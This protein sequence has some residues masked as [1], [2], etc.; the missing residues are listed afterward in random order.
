VRFT[1]ED[2]DAGRA[3]IAGAE[4]VVVVVVGASAVI[5]GADDALVPPPP[6]PPPPPLSQGFGGEAM[7]LRGAFFF[8]SF[9]MLHGC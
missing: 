8:M 3:G 7:V 4:V 9:V 1:T 6:P 2:R 5:V